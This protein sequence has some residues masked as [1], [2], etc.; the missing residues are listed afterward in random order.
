M[1]IVR[2]QLV[3]HF[4]PNDSVLIKRAWKNRAGRKTEPEAEV[5]R[6][7]MH[8]WGCLRARWDEFY[9]DGLPTDRKTGEMV[10][11]VCQPA[12]FFD[13]F[14]QLLQCQWLCNESG[15]GL[16]RMRMKHMTGS[17]PDVRFV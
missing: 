2:E 3:A 16:A 7:I 17:S 13:D 15:R 9:P 8:A 14:V 5:V 1:N 6:A 4:N 12:T 10:W 11:K